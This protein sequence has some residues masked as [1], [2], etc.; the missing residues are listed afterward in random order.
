MDFVFRRAYRGPIKAVIFDWAGT[1]VDY[2]CC[3]PARVFMKVFADH[4]VDITEAQAREPMGLMKRDHI[5]I[6][7]QMAPVAERWQA[8]HDRPPSEDDVEHL[9][10]DFIPLQLA[11]LADHADP[12]PGALALLAE[13][14]KRGIKVGSTTGY[15]HEMMDILAP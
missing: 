10:A 15:N 3:A 13:L 5:R 6:I 14:R 1:T 7:S 2:G 12:I 11:I 8:V 9:Y 4:G